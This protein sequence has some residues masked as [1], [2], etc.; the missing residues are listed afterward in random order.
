M[1]ATLTPFLNIIWEY[2]SMFVFGLSTVICCPQM[3]GTQS[4]ESETLKDDFYCT[5]TRDSV[6][7]KSYITHIWSMATERALKLREQGTLNHPPNYRLLRLTGVLLHAWEFN[8][9][10]RQ[11]DRLFGQYILLYTLRP[12]PKT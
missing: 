1:T 9:Y 7:N 4:W 11:L 8:T 3:N 12:K 10:R 2:R 5:G 6:G